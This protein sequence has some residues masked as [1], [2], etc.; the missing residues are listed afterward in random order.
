MNEFEHAVILQIFKRT[1]TFL[2]E[3][4]AIS[5]R[6]LVLHSRGWMEMGTG[7][8]GEWNGLEPEESLK[9]FV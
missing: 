4:Y 6:A 8:E 7:T 3:N 9:L 1:N 2:L 5:N